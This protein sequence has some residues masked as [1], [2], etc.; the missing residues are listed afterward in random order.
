MGKVEILLVTALTL[1]EDVTFCYVILKK[2][3]TKPGR[4]EMI[5]LADGTILYFALLM[6]G[7]DFYPVMYLALNIV[8]LFLIR[9]L[10]GTSLK[11]TVKIWIGLFSFL[12]IVETILKVIINII[13]PFSDQFANI[14]LITL[15]V[16]FLLW[17]YYFLI[18]RRMHREKNKFST[19]LWFLIEGLLLIYVLIIT[20]VVYLLKSVQ[21]PKLAVMGGVLVMLGGAGAFGMIVAIMYYFQKTEEYRVQSEMIEM[22]NEQQ[23]EYFLNLLDREQETKKFRHDIINHLM[24]IQS[25]CK[26]GDMQIKNYISNLLNNRQKIFYKQFDVGNDIVNVIINYYLAPAQEKCGITV[27]GYIGEIEEISG[28]DLCV[29]VS[30]LVKNAVE[31]VSHMQVGKGEIYFF[32]NKGSQ[33]LNIYVKNSFERHINFDTKGLPRTSKKEKADH[34][35]GIRNVKQAV[36]KY[37]GR[38]DIRVENNWYIANVF[39]KL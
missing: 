22:Y 16:I 35:F 31:A 30:N 4:R 23:K 1:I 29:V 3:C 36:E 39:F 33:Y 17:I 32:I 9:F 18:G 27:K 25:F 28:V 19:R 21:A 37:D 11:E 8:L 38:F 24:I 2:R 10:Y 7:Y 34:G 6:R 14:I 12:V 5:G 20:F 15:I 13:M 26:E